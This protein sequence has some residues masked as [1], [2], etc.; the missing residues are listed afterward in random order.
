MQVLGGCVVGPVDPAGTLS[1]TEVAYT[2]VYADDCTAW[3]GHYASGKLVL[4]QLVCLH[5]ILYGQV[6]LHSFRLQF[7]GH[8]IV[9]APPRCGGVTS[10]RVSM[11]ELL[12]AQPLYD[13]CEQHRAFMALSQVQ[14]TR[15]G[16]FVWADLR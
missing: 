11:H 13:P 14:G 12:T 3:V 5:G 10:Y 16:L 2:Y 15:E 7:T 6:G 4:A 1:S 8:P 9:G